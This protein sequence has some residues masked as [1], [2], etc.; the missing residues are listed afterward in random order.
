MK[1]KLFF[2]LLLIALFVWSCDKVEQPNP[3]EFENT[4]CKQTNP[5]LKNN[6][7]V[8]SFRKVLVEDYTGH[9]CGNCPTAAVKAESLIAT[10]GSSIV[11]IANHVSDQFAKP[12]RDTASGKYREDFRNPASTDWDVTLG[13]SSAG[14]PKGAVNRI[15]KPTYP[16]NPGVWT[17]L[18]PA[19]LAKPQSVK[20]DVSTSYDPGKKI[21]DVKVKSTFLTSVNA[22]VYLSLIITQDSIISDQ[23]DYT[24]PPSQATDPDDPDRR[25]NYRFDH[26]VVTSLNGSW[27]DL[28]K[29][30]PVTGDTAT[31]S[32]NCFSVSKC[33]FKNIVCLNDNHLSLVAFTYNATTKEILQV[34]KVKLR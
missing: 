25:V 29:K 22:D 34:E 1:F 13:M 7:S 15:Q 11:V 12:N 10:Y 32:K 21:L 5:I 20:M 3:H 26:I 23:K 28:V 6:F 18:V 17:S 27:G 31:I 8:S 30:S 14:L 24:M 4:D 19:E 33:F 9:Y 16:Q 2:P